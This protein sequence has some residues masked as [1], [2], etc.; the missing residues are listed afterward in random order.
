MIK[1]AISQPAFDAFVATMKLGSVGYENATDEQ[2]Q[3]PIWLDP[4]VNSLRALRW[5]SE[6]YSDVIIRMAAYNA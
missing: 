4:V 1:I 6:S 2:G 5:P 3:R